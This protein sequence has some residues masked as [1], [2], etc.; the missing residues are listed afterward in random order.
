MRYGGL[1]NAKA[2]SYPYCKKRLELSLQ[3]YERDGN[4]EHLVDAGN[5]CYLMFYGGKGEVRTHERSEEERL[6]S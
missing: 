4:R 1:S 6:T 2:S 3:A 5:W